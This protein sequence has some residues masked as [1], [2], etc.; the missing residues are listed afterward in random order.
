MQ[1]VLP[2][3]FNICIFYVMLLQQM[4]ELCRNIM[5]LKSILYGN[6]ESDPISEACAQ[7]TVEFFRENTLRL[8]IKC[9]PKL[10]LEVI[11]NLEIGLQSFQS[12]NECYHGCTICALGSIHT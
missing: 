9:L 8:L 3:V 2:M 4:S 6:G 12:K 11:R 5:E 1:A 10:N 7:L